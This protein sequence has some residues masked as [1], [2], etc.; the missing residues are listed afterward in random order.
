MLHEV[1]TF[2]FWVQFRQLGSLQVWQF[3][4]EVVDNPRPGLHVL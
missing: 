2:A 3:P 4:A 1:H